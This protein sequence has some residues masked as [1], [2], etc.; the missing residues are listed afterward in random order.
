MG[1]SMANMSTSTMASMSSSMSGMATST[2]ASMSSSMSGMSG[3]SSAS[4]S[5]NSSST[6]M[7]MKMH[8]NT[9]VTAKWLNYPV[10]FKNLKADTRG[11]L[12]GIF[13]LVIVVTFVYKLTSFSLWYLELKWSPRN[14]P[15]SEEERL[16]NEKRGR[17]FIGEIFF[18]NGSDFFKDIIRTVLIFWSTLLAYMLMLVAMTYIL[19][20]IFAIVL[21]I[22]LF[23]V[24]FNRVK[25]VI[26]R[27]RRLN[28]IQSCKFTNQGVC[29]CGG[30]SKDSDSDSDITSIKSN[31]CCQ[32]IN[33][34]TEKAM[35][36]D[37]QVVNNANEIGNQNAAEMEVELDPRSRFI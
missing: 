35:D 30:H 37:E 25:I 23:E 27:N 9:Y 19:T 21:G 13:L 36:E 16:M 3:M 15:L 26:L 6:H 22:A 20:Y 18:P 5:T 14:E 7:H 1:S 34:I 12:F 2:M 24:F 33:S 10:V 31:T 4:N 17:S 11:K 28:V 8:M 32:N 29:T